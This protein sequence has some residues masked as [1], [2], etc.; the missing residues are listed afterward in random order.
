MLT[1]LAGLRY[2]AAAAALDCPVGTIRSQVA[3]ARD[4]L[5]DAAPAAEANRVRRPFT[6]P[7]PTHPWVPAG[8]SAR[9]GES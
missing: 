1:Q 3:R 5:F 8:A 9:P 4:Q 2:A 7:T 6:L